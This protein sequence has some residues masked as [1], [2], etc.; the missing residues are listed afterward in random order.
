MGKA[1]MSDRFASKLGEK[2]GESMG[3]TF[4]E[5]TGKAMGKTMDTMTRVAGEAGFFDEDTQKSIFLFKV[6]VILVLIGIA[7]AGVG[8]VYLKIAVLPKHKGIQNAVYTQASSRAYL[9]QDYGIVL[10]E[11]E[12]AGFRYIETRAI[13]DLVTGWITKEGTIDE[14][15]IDGESFIEGEQFAQDAHVVITYHAFDSETVI[16]QRDDELGMYLASREFGDVSFSVPEDWSEYVYENANG[17]AY[18]YDDHNGMIDDNS[19]F[20]LFGV[21]AVS[22]SIH[23]KD[24]VE[25]LATAI[26]AVDVT[27]VQETTICDYSA[28]YFEGYLYNE[29]VYLKLYVIDYDGGQAAF[30][31][32]YTGAD[33]EL[34]DSVFDRFIESIEL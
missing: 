17:I 13:D 2:M 8:F 3:R 9:K 5:A 22:R 4:G 24:Y 7:A 26:R 31:L 14:I 27:N 25:S 12:N 29:N 21:P 6:K 1:S 30:G 28:V 11:F 19:V 32:Y 23:D 20:V 15:T 16:Y 10:S 18:C 34:V 33:S